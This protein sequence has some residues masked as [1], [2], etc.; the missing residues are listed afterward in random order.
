MPRSERI[1]SYTAQEIERMRA[2]G[3]D[4]TD[5]AALDHMSE[6]ELERRIAADPDAETG[7]IDWATLEVH[8][9]RSKRHMTLRLDADVVDWFRAQGSGYQTRMNAVLRAYMEARRRQA[10]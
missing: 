8:P 3:E 5:W 2:R 9:P 6:E 4:R 7:P 10:G 1:V